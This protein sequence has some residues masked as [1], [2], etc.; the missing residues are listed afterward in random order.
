METRGQPQQKD[1]VGMKT[2]AWE[3]QRK[4]LPKGMGLGHGYSMRG[5]GRALVLK[6]SNSSHHHTAFS[7]SYNSDGLYLG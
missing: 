2:G 5:K 3:K 7:V 6:L 1:K 4:S